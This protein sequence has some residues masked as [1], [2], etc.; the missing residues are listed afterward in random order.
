MA[1]TH[2]K[3][4]SGIDGLYTGSKGYEVQMF[5]N[6]VAGKRYYVD[7]N[8]GV[9]SNNGSSWTRPFKTLTKAITASNTFL[10]ISGNKA[11]WTQRNQIFYKGD[12]NEADSETITT[13]ANKCDIIGMGSYDHRPM[14]MLIGNIVVG[15]TA[16]MGCRFINMGFMSPAAGGVIFTA[17]TTT[18]GLAFIGCHFDGRSTTPATEAIKITAVDQCSIVGCRFFGKYS[19]ATIEAGTGATRLLKINDNF[20]ESGAIG[21]LTHASMTCA[22]S[23]AQILNNVFDVV[24][25][26]IDENSD[27][28]L[29]GGNRGRTQAD[30]T[31]ALTID[32]NDNMAY[33]NIFAH[34]AG[35]SQYPVLITIPA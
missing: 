4:V 3:G 34:S 23:V 5:G 26:C 19:T 33:D 10:A 7:A 29:V 12:N 13:L 35:V 15:A 27:K 16:Y 30:G 25:L 8:L 18:S 1:I 6:E 2:F 21:I 11:A 20:I 32:Y 31:V 14:P 17:P 9:D 24:T 28:V 22:D